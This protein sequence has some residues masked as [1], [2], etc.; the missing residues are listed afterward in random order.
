[1][2][3]SLA[4]AAK[5]SPPL[6][7][8]PEA[9]PA[10]AAFS[11]AP[12]VRM[13]RGRRLRRTKSITARPEASGRAVMDLVRR[14][15]RPRDIRTRGAIENAAGAGAASGGST[16]GGLHLAAIA[17]EV[18]IEFDLHAFGEICNRTPY[19]ADLKPAGRYV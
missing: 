12:L 10:P 17:N 11:I 16:K 1:M 3:T 8:P 9:A 19:I 15:L 18:G 5:C 4:I 2:P 6:V 7:E 14:N 13:S